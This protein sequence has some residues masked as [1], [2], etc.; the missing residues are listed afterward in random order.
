MDIIQECIR[1][2]TEQQN[3]E[4]EKTIINFLRKSGYE[5][6]DNPSPHDIRE[7]QKLLEADNKRL[8]VEVFMKWNGKLS[9]TTMILPFFEALDGKEI[10]RMD[11]YKMFNLVEQGY[12]I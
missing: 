1:E 5:V 3:N 10:S 11:V 7:L 2:Y 12:Q 8:R 6:D 9:I 4:L